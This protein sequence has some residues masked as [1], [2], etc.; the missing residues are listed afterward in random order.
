LKKSLAP[1][2]KRRN[3]LG[4]SLRAFLALD[5]A[6][7]LYI[8]ATQGV[9]AWYSDQDSPEALRQ[10]IRW[11]PNNPAYY[12]DL[13]KFAERS[14]KQG[15]VKESIEL[16]QQATALSP[17][18]ADYWAALGALYEWDGQQENAQAAFER[19]SLLFPGSV[20]ISWKT[21]NFYLRQGRLD[22]AIPSLQKAMLDDMV[23][24]RS[25]FELVWQATGDP[26]LVAS[27]LVPERADLLLAYL[28]YLVTTERMSEAARVW[29]R[30][31][32]N[33]FESEPRAAFPYVDALIQHR[34]IDQLQ[35][36]WGD[37]EKKNPPRPGERATDANLI[38]NGDFESKILNGGLDW[39]ISPAEGVVV[40]VDSVNFFDGTHSLRIRFDGKHNPSYE[41]IFQYVPVKAGTTYSF[42]AYMRVRGITTDSGLR[43][44]CFDADEPA[45][46][47]FESDNLVGTSSW[48]P[49]QAEFTTG[50][51][52]R[53]LVI[54]VVRPASRKFD[55]Q[56]AG[57]AWIDRISL[58]E[59]E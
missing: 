24:A 10:A 4:I 22:L 53:L 15:N 49:Q 2:P 21:G 29:D 40:S 3:W 50:P 7:C 55:S 57:T 16:Y 33:G 38:T 17:H 46:L 1:T 58:S 6:L 23:L 44:Q 9:A 35:E 48:L 36:A 32:Q 56:I 47:I 34:Q 20:V 19:A 13:A 26:H 45:K 37:I 41:S 18:N 12:A 11:D 39:R 51:T 31:V 27:K 59:V 14:F 54:R 43:F 25:S 5:L 30:L 52:T 42:S 8:V 28:D